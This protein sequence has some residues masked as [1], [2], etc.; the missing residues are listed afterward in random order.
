MAEDP[1]N[2]EGPPDSPTCRDCGAPND[3]GASECWLCHRW[4]WRGTSAAPAS[5]KAESTTTGSGG[6]SGLVSLVL[7][8]VGFGVLAAAPWLA[9]VIVVLLLPAW[10]LGMLLTRWL[11]D[12]PPS[13]ATAAGIAR[14]GVLVVLVPFLVGLSVFVALGM[15]CFRS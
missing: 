3:P 1:L 6:A 12:R 4:D 5:A 7:V 10:G 13:T 15:L 2:P 8:L 14:A 9:L 11:R